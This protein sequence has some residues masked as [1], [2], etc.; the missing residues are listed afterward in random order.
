M[1]PTR[2]AIPPI[3]YAIFC[4]YEPM[5]TTMGFV[6]TLLDP[7]KVII[8]LSTAFPKILSFVDTN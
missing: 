2:S 4:I 1:P 7:T 6:G 5:L 3:Y 8:L